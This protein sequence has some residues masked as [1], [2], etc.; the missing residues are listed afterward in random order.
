MKARAWW[1]DSRTSKGH[2]NA[3]TQALRVAIKGVGP[4]T[5]HHKIYISHYFIYIYR[6]CWPVKARKCLMQI[7]S[8]ASICV[9]PLT[10]LP[11]A[12]R[13][14]SGL[15]IWASGAFRIRN[16]PPPNILEFW[17]FYVIVSQAEP[18]VAIS[19]LKD[20]DC[21]APLGMTSINCPATEH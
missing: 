21:F 6:Y 14:L 13:A 11:Y 8:G 5:F 19:L 3:P 4:L 16:R 17:P 2:R 1:I 7:L 10:L 12:D 9:E 15:V 18:S 20:G